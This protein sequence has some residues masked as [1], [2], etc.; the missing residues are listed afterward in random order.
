MTGPMSPGNGLDASTNGHSR[1][2]MHRQSAVQRLPLRSIAAVAAAGLFLLLLT[3]SLHK[4]ST[5]SRKAQ[6][7]RSLTSTLGVSD[8]S[9]MKICSAQ[10]SV[11]TYDGGSARTCLPELCAEREKLQVLHKLSHDRRWST[12]SE[13]KYMELYK[14]EKLGGWVDVCFRVQ[15]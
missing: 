10:Q 2:G 12:E 9:S 3:G 4:A 6:S 5:S 1:T 15:E 8:S 7:I 14:A 11:V 13:E